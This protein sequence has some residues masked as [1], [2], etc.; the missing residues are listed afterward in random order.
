MRKPHNNKDSFIAY[1]GSPAFLSC[2]VL[3]IAHPA[4]ALGSKTRPV[5]IAA[6]ILDIPMQS[7]RIWRRLVDGG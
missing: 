2:S 1:I 3:P 4:H 7:V 6:R 5:W